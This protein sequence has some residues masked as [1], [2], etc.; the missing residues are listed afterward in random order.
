LEEAAQIFRNPVL[1]VEDN[2]RDYGER[3]FV[4]SCSFKGTA[5]RVVFTHRDGNI[6]LT[7]FLESKQK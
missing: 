2:L 1:M 7:F 4:A 5:L 3:R 6:R